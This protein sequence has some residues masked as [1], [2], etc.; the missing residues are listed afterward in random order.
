MSFF[1]KWK[2]HV[3]VHISQDIPV[4]NLETIR[5]INVTG[6]K[7]KSLPFKNQRNLRILLVCLMF[8]SSESLFFFLMWSSRGVGPILTSWFSRR[9]ITYV[10][11][12]SERPLKSGCRGGFLDVPVQRGGEVR[13]AIAE[14]GASLESAAGFSSSPLG[15]SEQ[16][17]KESLVRSK[18]KRSLSSRVASRCLSPPNVLWLVLCG[19]KPVSVAVCSRR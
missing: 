8:H 3:S 10:Q 9:R 17:K 14:V 2:I 16:S 7:E 12:I 13:G 18:D 6:H 1:M 11:K 15:P 5:Q 4:L 19:L